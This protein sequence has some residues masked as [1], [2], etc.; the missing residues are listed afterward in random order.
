MTLYRLT[1]SY[2]AHFLFGLIYLSC[3]LPTILAQPDLTISQSLI[4]SSLSYEKRSFSDQCL[5]SEK[6]IG[7]LGEREILRF[8][9]EIQNIG[10]IDYYIGKPPTDPL[11]GNAQFTWDEC[12]RHWHFKAY[13]K[14]G[15]YT[16]TGTEL[17]TSFK[18]GFCVE[19]LGKIIPTAVPKYT[20][21]N[22]GITAGCYDKYDLNLP[23]Q[24]IDITGLPAATYK[25]VV[26]VNWTKQKDNNGRDESNYNNNTATVFFKITRNGNTATVNVVDGPTLPPSPTGLVTVY[27]NNDYTG[28]VLNFNEGTFNSTDLGGLN[29]KIS[30]LLVMSGF[31]VRACRADGYCRIFTANT[32]FVGSDLNNQI[33]SLEISS[34]TT[35]PPP[36]CALTA[37]ATTVVPATCADN[38]GRVA[39]TITGGT[40]PYQANIDA[41]TTFSTTLSFGGLTTGAHSANIKD[42]AGCTTKVNFTITKNCTTPTPNCNNILIYPYPNAATC[43]DTDGS[44][45]ATVFGG[46]PPY[47]FSVDSKAFQG[48]PAF[49]GLASGAHTLNIKDNVG[50]TA[51]KNFTIIKN[52]TAPIPNCANLTAT[53]FTIPTTCAGNDGSVDKIVVGG[54]APYQ[55][56]IDGGAFQKNAFFNNLNVGAHYITIKDTNGCTLR[57]DFSI[58]KN[59]TTT[60][61]PNCANLITSLSPIA[62]TCAGNDGALSK[63]VLGGTAPYQFS[64]DGAAFQGTPYFS[65][66]A[67]GAHYVTIKDNAGCNV[68]KDFAITKNCTTP[69]PTCNLTIASQ[70]TATTCAG[71]DGKMTLTAS[72]GTAPYTYSVDGGINQTNATFSGLTE[73]KHSLTVKDKLGCAS[74][75]SI[76]ITKNCTTAPTGCTLS[77]THQATNATCAASDGTAKIITSGGVAPFLYGIDGKP[78]QNTP[79]F[80]GLKVGSHYIWV[81]DNAGCMKVVTFTTALNCGTPITCSLAATARMVAATCLGTDGTVTV[82]A[83]GGTAPY[84]YSLD[85]GALQ[86]NPY[87]TGLYEGSHNIMVKD[88]TG[89]ITYIG[90]ITIK[91]CARAGQDDTTEII[92]YPN[93]S[94]KAVHVWMNESFAERLSKVQVYDSLGNVLM[95]TDARSQEIAFELLKDGLYLVVLHVKDGGTVTKKIIINDKIE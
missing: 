36:T 25:L 79:A 29:L 16:D 92:V 71:N 30:S 32:A 84:K 27:E 69:N 11:A 74:I 55:F 51:V 33:V 88:N 19:D 1:R 18:N 73:G 2:H 10:N 63:I 47:Q 62:A 4:K 90:I 46:V 80:S 43:I 37:N 75:T 39:L 50:C 6:C 86:T 95:E 53:L 5:L 12:H 9:T 61:P 57:K 14:Y 34:K 54:S 68:R 24:W 72:G 35:I 31:Q 42:N 94:H 83:T 77:I 41:A 21:D 91:N 45:S 38:D 64:I 52:C 13:A 76:T 40:P 56:S 59:C 78:W 82:T 8:S 70:L 60:P 20:C 7:N 66:L 23:C 28:N 15:L 3:C 89:C 87:F 26:D 44:V 81:R 67:A 17:P 65:N 85:G 49:F 58:T 48:A 93:P 22:Q